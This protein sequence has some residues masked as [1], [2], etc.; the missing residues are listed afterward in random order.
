MFLGVLFILATK[1]VLSSV[2]DEHEAFGG[3]HSNKVPLENS[4]MPR[5][6][7]FEKMFLIMF[8]MTLHSLT[9]GIGM[10]ILAAVIE[11]YCLNRS[12]FIYLFIYLFIY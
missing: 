5:S 10:L 9:E 12:S 2:E 11:M 4:D 7:G 3:N 1:Q 8:V 6:V